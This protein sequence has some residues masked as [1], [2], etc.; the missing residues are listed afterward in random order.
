[1]GGMGH[2]NKFVLYE[3]AVQDPDQHIVVFDRIFADLFDRKPRSLREGF[4]GTFFLCKRWVEGDPGRT[5]VGLDLDPRVL[6][7]GRRRHWRR[8]DPAARRRLQVRRQDVRSVTRPGVDV[9]SVGNFSFWALKEWADL[10][11]Y[12]RCVRRSLNRRGVVVLETAGGAGMMETLR[13]Q[14]SHKRDGSF[15]FRY[16]W[17][18]RSFNPISHHLMCTISF[19]LADGR[20]LR[21][22]FVYDWRLWTLPEIERALYEAGFSAV[23]HYWEGRG[24]NGNGLAPYRSVGRGVNSHHWIAYVVGIR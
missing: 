12:L 18:Q 10:V 11:H 23:R 13:E 9:V 24:G 21:D 19:E 2:A 15:W 8:L 4:C 16:V 17:R 7:E 22:A 1:V 20:E 5:A 6:A 14:T 3:E